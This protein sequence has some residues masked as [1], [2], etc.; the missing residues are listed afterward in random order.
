MK[1]KYK[2]KEIELLPADEL[3][4]LPPEYLMN[5]PQNKIEELLKYLKNRYETL[6]EMYNS[7]TL[8]PFLLEEDKKIDQIP[9][10][11][12][13][14]Q[15]HIY[16]MLGLN[17]IFDYKNDK[18]Y[19][20]NSELYDYIRN[21]LIEKTFHKILLLLIAE[22]HQKA[23]SVENVKSDLSENIAKS[24]CMYLH[25]KN[26][27]NT[28]EF[29][30]FN[31][32]AHLGY[33]DNLSLNGYSVRADKYSRLVRKIKD[34]FK[35][36][37]YLKKFSDFYNSYD[38]L[39][40][41]NNKLMYLLN[42][43]DK[44]D[45]LERDY[46]LWLSINPYFDNTISRY[47]P[48]YTYY[49]F[50]TISTPTMSS[51]N[52]KDNLRKKRNYTNGV[53]KHLKYLITNTRRPTTPSLNDILVDFEYN[54]KIFCFIRYNF[55][56][57]Y[58]D[59]EINSSR[60][61]DLEEIDMLTTCNRVAFE[62]RYPLQFYYS[63]NTDIVKELIDNT[64][65][66]KEIKNFY[67]TNGTCYDKK[68]MN[69]LESIFNLSKFNIN[70]R[71]VQQLIDNTSNTTN[72]NNYYLEIIDIINNFI[73]NKYPKC[74]N[75]TANCMNYLDSFDYFFEDE[76]DNFWE[77]YLGIDNNIPDLD[78]IK[79]FIKETCKSIDY[80]TMKYEKQETINNP[81]LSKLLYGTPDEINYIMT[82]KNSIHSEFANIRNNDKDYIYLLLLA[83]YIT[84]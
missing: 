30:T 49:C 48:L 13:Y 56:D 59:L 74:I 21:K 23:R 26:L 10:H 41:I 15:W 32:D 38:D 44:N 29:T 4:N 84:K 78:M 77:L 83:T 75:L 80:L 67:I 64:F 2:I 25:A 65:S 35:S 7:N 9:P 1:G 45:G 8:I 11:T 66:R 19:Q 81:I 17:T 37:D 68:K 57:F 82:S 27:L 33:W 53:L 14:R 63:L 61:S 16:I 39:I 12:E 6:N 52:K 36:N 5:L 22:L 55:K 79:Y 50:N 47:F 54:E 34:S 70:M 60:E 46:Y 20:I 3:A 58:K 40:P 28:N 62:D 76:E 43:Y 72:S 18:L 24:I 51:N 73:K 71:Y 69:I 42:Y 31:V